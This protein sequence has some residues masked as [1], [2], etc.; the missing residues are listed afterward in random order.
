MKPVAVIVHSPRSDIKWVR[1]LLEQRDVPVRLVRLYSGGPLPDPGDVAAAVSMGGPMSAYG[2]GRAPF[3]AAEEEFLGRAV[4]AGLPVL[5]ICLG[6]QL[7]AGVLGGAAVPG[8]HGL[9]GGEIEVTVDPG[10]DDPVLAGRSGTYFSF[11]ADSFRFPPGATLLAWSDRYPQ[12][13]RLGTALGIQFHPEI[14]P[15]GVRLLAEVEHERLRAAG[16]DAEAMVAAA[17]RRETRSRR[18]ADAL[19]GGWID[20]EVRAAVA[21][22]AIPPTE[23]LGGPR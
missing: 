7:L 17:V 18:Q 5:G 9:E 1:R 15:A 22:P 13:Y 11:H 12:A 4:A 20:R 6:A 8:E 10:T 3:L 21:T 16:I 14:S 23:H 2:D 19:L